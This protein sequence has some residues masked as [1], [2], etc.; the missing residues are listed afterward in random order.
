MSKHRPSF[1][2]VL[3]IS[4]VLV[5]I[6]L[7][8]AD[9]SPQALMKARHDHYHELGDAFKVIRDESR[10]GTPNLP[11]IKSAAKLVNDA[12]RDQGKWFPAGTGPKAGKTRAK[13]DI[14]TRPQEFVAAQKM[15]SDS[16]P[17]LL[18]AANAGDIAGVKSQYGEVGKSCKNCH[19]AFR[20]PE[21]H[22]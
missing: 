5:P 1:S 6:A 22:E 9:T 21:D 17:K 16:A 7:L 14:W 2:A 12:S 8:A 20:S 3:T 13:E 10:A 11:A 15:F 18:A 4:A 19:D